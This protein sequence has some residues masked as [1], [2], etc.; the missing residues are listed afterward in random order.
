MAVIFVKI[1][2]TKDTVACFI[3]FPSDLDKIRVARRAQTFLECVRWHAASRILLGEVSDL[4][5][6]FPRLI[7]DV[8]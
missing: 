8:R 1:C 2:A 4:C 3:L 6:R 7:F 5:L